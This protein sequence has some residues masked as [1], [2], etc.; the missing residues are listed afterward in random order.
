VRIKDPEHIGGILFELVPSV[1]TVASLLDLYI[2]E[3]V[4]D[5]VVGYVSSTAFNRCCDMR[6]TWLSISILLTLSRRYIVGLSEKLTEL[7]QRDLMCISITFS[8]RKLS[9]DPALSI[10]CRTAELII[11]VINGIVLGTPVSTRNRNMLP[12]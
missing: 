7:M 3:E 11:S 9:T 5:L 4:I 10:A 1:V 8:T 6:T 2:H 12:N